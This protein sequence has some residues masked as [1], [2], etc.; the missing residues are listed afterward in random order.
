MPVPIDVRDL[1]RHGRQMHEERERPVR[2]VV[3]L[4]PGAPDDL[5]DSVRS[6]LRPQTAFG[7]VAVEVVEPGFDIGIDASVDVVVAVAGP[8][9]ADLRRALDAPTRLAVPV[10]VVGIGSNN[11]ALAEALVHP[12]TDTIVGPEAEVV[13]CRDLADWFVDRLA[14]KR[15]AF[16][17]NFGFIRREVA[18]DA[19]NVTAW[20]NALIGGVIIIP[21]ADMPLMTANQA[22]MVLQIA[23]AY[24]QR[25]GPD[26]IK[27]LAAVAGGGFMF[28][29]VARQLLTLVPGF[30]WALKAGIGY[31]GTLAMGRAAIAYFERGADLGF[32]TR[33]VGEVRDAVISRF[34]RLPGRDASPRMALQ[35][36]EAVVAEALDDAMPVPPS[37]AGA[38]P[39]VSLR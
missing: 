13:V 7:H 14:G 36:A 34:D 30:G 38:R 20:Q 29:T 24:G 33:K 28:R 35:V 15:M 32:V 3:L 22:K 26:R 19:V 4:E 25:L 10:A 6:H 16:S 18:R 37:A 39:P 2:V 31:A 12:L 21:G 1:L 17:Y 11:A 9:G 5:L 27:E 23:A 8:G